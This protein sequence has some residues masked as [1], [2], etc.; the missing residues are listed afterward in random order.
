MMLQVDQNKRAD[1]YQ[2]AKFAFDMIGKPCPVR[3][4][5]VS[6]RP[7]S[8]VGKSFGLFYQLKGIF[9]VSLSN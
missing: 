8:V 2:V 6:L 5:Q 1:I 3:Y 7:C 9:F 4:M